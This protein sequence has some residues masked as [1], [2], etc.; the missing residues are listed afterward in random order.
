MRLSLISRDDLISPAYRQEQ[1]RLHRAGYGE[2]GYKWADEV[3]AAAHVTAASMPPGDVLKILDYGCGQGTLGK[4]L[5]RRGWD[6]ANYDPA[7]SRFSKDPDPADFVICNDVL[8][9]V[10][11]DKIP[12][13]L[14]HLYMLARHRVFAVV[15][16][17]ETAK[18][19]SDGRQ[20]HISL[21]PFEWW[22]QRFREARLYPT[23][24]H[25]NVAKPEKCFAVLLRPWEGEN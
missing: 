8:E 6:V 10:E 16:T 11:D 18:T 7:V 19:L 23:D 17:V 25:I 14:S 12:T 15:S 21:H 24:Y 22:E 20:A 5:A 9:H 13:V 1:E 2:K 4:E 3:E